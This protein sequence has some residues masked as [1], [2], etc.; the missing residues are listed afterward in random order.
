MIQESSIPPYVPA[1][2]QYVVLALVL[3]AMAYL[4]IIILNNSGSADYHH[5]GIF[6]VWFLLLLYIGSIILNITDDYKQERQMLNRKRIELERKVDV[7][8]TE[9][10]MQQQL[11]LREEARQLVM[12]EE[13]EKNKL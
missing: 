9:L 8:Q 4:L 10:Y 13:K 7:K 5:V 2:W 6:I 12:A 1:V 11:K 3:V